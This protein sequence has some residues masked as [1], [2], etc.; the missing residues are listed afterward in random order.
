MRES[1]TAVIFCRVT[2]VYLTGLTRYFDTAMAV[3]PLLYLQSGYDR[4]SSSHCSWSTGSIGVNTLDVVA[5]HPDRFPH[6]RARRQYQRQGDAGAMQTLQPR[7]AVLLDEPSADW[8]RPEVRAAG[9][10]YRSPPGAVDRSKK[11]LRSG[12]GYR[13]GGHRRRSR[14]TPTLPPLARASLC[15]WPTRKSLVMAGRIFMDVVKQWRHAVPIDS[16]HNA[17]FQSLPHHFGEICTGS[18]FAAF[19]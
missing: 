5:R 3:L 9:L 11:L 12:C 15:C 2:V 14:V 7:Y 16:E 8:L 6:H 4:H 13:N 1:R 17:M 18:G 19:C 10:R